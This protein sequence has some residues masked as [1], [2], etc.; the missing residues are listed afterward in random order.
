MGNTIGKTI[1][2]VS[3]PRL[4]P[5]TAK[6]VTILHEKELAR[7]S[8]LKQTSSQDP[9]ELKDTGLL[10]NPTIDVLIKSLKSNP[11]DLYSSAVCVAR[12]TSFFCVTIH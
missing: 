2:S 5:E 6:Q 4:D 8:N 12:S 3:K 10:E 11:M 9:I 7:A 1:R